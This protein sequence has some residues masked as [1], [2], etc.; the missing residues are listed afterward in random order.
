MCLIV[1][2]S[3]WCAGCSSSRR[4]VQ[5]HVSA[6]ETA[7]IG[8]QRT[9][10]RQRRDTAADQRTCTVVTT[11][12][13]E[14]YDTSRPADTRSSA[15]PLRRRVVATTRTRTER[16]A[17]AAQTASA[18]ESHSAQA[19]AARQEQTQ[20]QTDEQRK[21]APSRGWGW[22]KTGIFVALGAVIAG[23]ALKNRIKNLLKPF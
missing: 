6:S 10:V 1:V 12:T 23:W 5:A 8:E 18:A 13:I 20:L 19:Q 7:R 3:L 21:P 17:A 16:K 15:P 9:L 14:E 4:T 11:T 2:C 22:F